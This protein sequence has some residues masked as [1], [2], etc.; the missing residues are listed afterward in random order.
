MT[1]DRFGVGAFA[2]TVPC[3]TAQS[4]PAS[5]LGRFRA[6]RSDYFSTVSG[7]ASLSEGASGFE[8]SAAG[9]PGSLR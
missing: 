9:T 2:R 6:L 8:S 3:S 7:A 4:G 1:P 5:D